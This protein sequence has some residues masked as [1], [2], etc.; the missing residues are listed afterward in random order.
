[1]LI[2]VSVEVSMVLGILGYCCFLMFLGMVTCSW[3]V[4]FPS[5]VSAWK[6][7]V[8]WRGASWT[9]LFS[10]KTLEMHGGYGNV[11]C[12]VVI[13]G[14]NQSCAMHMGESSTTA[15][16]ASE[17]CWGHIFAKADLI[18][19]NKFTGQN[20][21]SLLAA[22][23]VEHRCGEL[24]EVIRRRKIDEPQKHSLQVGTD[25]NLHIVSKSG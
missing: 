11:C 23:W 5:L 17:R 6:V 3:W 14:H 21:W 16:Y 19:K 12:T 20:C 25:L 10:I 18:S 4:F 22:G 7:I 1:M 13:W 15:V 2:Q 9:K 24:G 8:W